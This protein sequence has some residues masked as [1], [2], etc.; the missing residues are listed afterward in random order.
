M[1]LSEVAKQNAEKAFRFFLS[2]GCTEAGAAGLIGNLYRESGLRS[3][4]VEELLLSRYREEGFLKWTATPYDTIN[5]SLYVS[6]YKTGD[7]SREEFLSPRQYTKQAHQYGFGLA[8]W[9]IRSRKEHLLSLAE[10]DRVS[11][12]NL[13]MQLNLVYAELT[14][15]YKAVWT[16][17]TS[18]ASVNDAT[19]AVLKNYEAPANADALLPARVKSAKEI[20]RIIKGEDTMGIIF[21]SAR[22]G[23]NGIVNG[24]QPGD[25][26]NVEVSTQPYYKHRKG[27]RVLRAKDADAANRIAQCMASAC[28]NNRIGYSQEK[29][30]TGVKIAQSVGWNTALIAN[31]C[32]VDCSSLVRICVAYG[33]GKDPGD[34]DTGAERSVL[35]GTGLFTDVTWGV[36]TTTGNGLCNGDILVT[37][38]K[39]H[40]GVIVSGATVRTGTTGTTTAK[41]EGVVYMFTCKQIYEG[42]P[43]SNDVYLAQ[44]ILKSRGLYKGA[45]DKEFGPQMASAVEAYQKARGLEVDKI[46]GKNTWKDMIALQEA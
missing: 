32:D 42:C 12:D 20:L 11:I 46:I 33:T 16:V 7:I 9:T 19:S 17:L 21:G 36:N 22:I 31:N 25:Q 26:T 41:K 6:R 8:Q 23:E 38:T 10:E 35:L 39:G 24:A 14:T 44:E 40:T 1:A 15:A 18:T 45:L 34:F 27:W 37:A 5:Y 13:D 43:A 3:N 2:C 4:Y 28:A 30:Y 29:R